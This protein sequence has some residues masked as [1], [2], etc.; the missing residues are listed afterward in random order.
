MPVICPIDQTENP[1]T[2]LVCTKCGAK[3]TSLQPGQT[4]SDGRFF[5]RSQLREDQFSLSFLA[6]DLKTRSSCV[7]REF[8]PSNPDDAQFKKRFVAA[9]KGLQSTPSSSLRILYFFTRESRCYTVCDPPTGPTL[10]EELTSSGPLSLEI[11]KQWIA[12]ILR[13]LKALHDASIFHGNLFSD[14]VVLG[15]DGSACL[16]DPVF[17]GYLLRGSHPPIL[18]MIEKDLRSAGLIGLEMVDGESEQGDLAGRLASL[19]DL[20][21]GV[22]LDYLLLDPSETPRSAERAA[23]LLALLSQ[24]KSE[25]PEIAIDL[26]EQAYNRSGSPRIRKRLDE[27]KAAA[28]VAAHRLGP[29]VPPATEIAPPPVRI[30]E[31]CQTP[32]NPG[33]TSCLSCLAPTGSDKGPVDVGQRDAKVPIS[34]RKPQGPHGPPWHL[35]QRLT[36]LA[37]VPVLVMIYWLSTR[38]PVEE[39][40]VRRFQM[41][42]QEIVA[43]EAVTLSWNVEGSAKV[44][45]TPGIGPVANGGEQVI[46]PAQETVYTLRATDAAGKVYQAT[47]HIT[48]IPK[49][50]ETS[51]LRFQ[52]T[53]QEIVVGDEVTLT[54]SVSGP[55]HTVEIAP[56]VGKV[57]NEGQQ[58]L[59]PAAD[60]VYTLYAT[61]LT[62]RVH[63]AT[64]RIVVRPRPAK[65]INDQ[66]NTLRPTPSPSAP[67][68]NLPKAQD[69]NDFENEKINDSFNKNQQALAAALSNQ[70]HTIR[71]RNECA[72]G[73]VTVA[74]RFQSLDRTWATQGWWH[75]DPHSDAVAS[76]AYSRNG[77]YYFYATGSG[78]TWSGK[79]GDLNAIDI[80]IVDDRQFT[81]T[82]PISGSAPGK[83][84]RIVKAFRKDYLGYGEHL[85][86]FTC[87]K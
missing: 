79:P 19:N 55:T 48:V 31:K 45:I 87:D 81:L 69:L 74:I 62:G 63:E 12:A 40:M 27:K 30:C 7:L 86:S 49:P 80:S 6:E 84:P 65:T 54:W 34:D 15:V 51:I 41:S 29:P 58:R 14:R 56:D 35:I 85:M 82:G 20:E 60:T 10:R 44:A 38:K 46:R 33:T 13:E 76:S 57:A 77:L 83:N 50:V 8:F 4:F 26:Y 53:R 23:E 5:I 9:A 42:R 39:V 24:A 3:L 2:S 28:Q 1:D 66:Q 43:G 75:V 68:E 37:I 59:T 22:T 25:S 47:S 78:R 17:L 70:Y 36:L 64:S 18:S 11:A 72:A 71:I 16:L 21:L 67:K 32:L 61:D 52:S 73:A